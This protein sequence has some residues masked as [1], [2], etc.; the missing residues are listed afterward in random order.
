MSQCESR[1][2]PAPD[3]PATEVRCELDGTHMDN[4]RGALRDFA[5]PGSVTHVEWY[6]SDRRSFRGEWPGLCAANGCRLPSGHP[7]EC[8]T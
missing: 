5:Y 2:R 3:N 8:A 4:H 7:R 1:I 6:Y